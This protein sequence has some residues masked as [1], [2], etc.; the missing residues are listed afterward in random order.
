MMRWDEFIHPNIL[1]NPSCGGMF[2][3]W[4]MSVY[5]H[6]ALGIRLLTETEN[7]SMKPKY[8]GEDVIGHPGPHHL[9]IWLD[10]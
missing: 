10:A 9:R 6:N 4:D 7:G 3:V 8:Y 1:G 5:S 2:F